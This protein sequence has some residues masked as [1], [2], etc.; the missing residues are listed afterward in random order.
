M[1]GFLLCVADLS[2]LPGIVSIVPTWYGMVSLFKKLSAERVIQIIII[3]LFSKFISPNST[4]EY[5]HQLCG[6]SFVPG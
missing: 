3:L 1:C 6:I 2:S 5:R 4:I